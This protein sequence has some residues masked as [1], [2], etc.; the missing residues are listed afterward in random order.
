MRM[1]RPRGGPRS[2]GRARGLRPEG[3]SDP[4]ARPACL[5][6][7]GFHPQR[8]P[9]FIGTAAPAI[10]RTDAVKRPHGAVIPAQAGIQRSALRVHPPAHVIIELRR[11]RQEEGPWAQPEVGLIGTDLK[12]FWIPACAG[13]TSG[14]R[15]GMTAD[16]QGSGDRPSAH[17]SRLTLRGFVSSSA[18]NWGSLG[19]GQWATDLR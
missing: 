19:N 9:V 12:H 2:C 15:C 17:E 11:I 14:G 18:E 16:C 4:N 7:T 10:V 5:H 6:A 13:M 8:S 3:S 1:R